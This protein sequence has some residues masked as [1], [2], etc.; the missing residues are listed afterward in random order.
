MKLRN[1]RHLAHGLAG[2][3]VGILVLS[4]GLH[5]ACRPK[6][7]AGSLADK[8]CPSTIVNFTGMFFIVIIVHYMYHTTIHD[9]FNYNY[10]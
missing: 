9:R 1:T 10:Y 8:N 3:Q 2:S 5:R 6:G 4:K 7:P